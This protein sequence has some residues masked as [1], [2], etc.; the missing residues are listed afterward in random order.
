MAGKG[1][2]V[3]EQT[4][5]E[6]MPAE[7][8]YVVAPDTMPET[9]TPDAQE[10]GATQPPAKEETETSRLKYLRR[11]ALDFGG[12][13]GA[14]IVKVKGVR[15]VAAVRGGDVPVMLSQPSDLF[16]AIYG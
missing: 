5:P 8:V 7:G 16:R 4:I 3:L 12:F 11:A 2:A 9:D 10:D 1:T 6:T 15:Y 13:D 14:D